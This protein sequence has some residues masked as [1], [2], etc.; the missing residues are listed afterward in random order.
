MDIV[1]IPQTCLAGQ[2]LPLAPKAS[3]PPGAPCHLLAEVHLP[4]LPAGS[5]F[6]PHAPFLTAEFQVCGHAWLPASG[7]TGAVHAPLLMA[8]RDIAGGAEARYAVSRHG[9]ALAAITLSDKGA[10]GLRQD[11]SG[12]LMASLIGG[13]VELAYSQNFIL[14][15]ETGPLRALLAELALGQG[16]DIICTSGGTGVGPR[17][18]TPQA[19]QSLLDLALPGITQAMLMASLAKTAMAVISRATAGLIGK[20]L[21]L[22]LPGSPK[23]VRECLEPVLPALAHALAK[24]H[25]DTA[26]CGG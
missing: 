3:M 8:C 24:I 5:V 20:C 10:A 2:I 9:Y 14:P 22:N 1:L 21:V 16:Y 13:A 19:T 12:P 23:A 6:Y 25:G 17:D 7:G 4:R 11:E 18:V 15:D 26:D